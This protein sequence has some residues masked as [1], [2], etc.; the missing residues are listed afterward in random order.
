MKKLL[1]TLMLGVAAIA[2][3]CACSDS[4]SDSVD[5]PLGDVNSQ[6]LSITAVETTSTR[7]T[8]SVD[9]KDPDIPYVC[10]YADKAT[11]D[12]VPKG[13]LPQFLMDELKAQAKAQ[14]KIAAD[15]IAEI[16]LRGNIDKKTVTGLH[17]GRIYELVAFAVS[18]TTVA[19]NAE[20]LFFETLLLDPIDCSF[21][22][23]AQTISNQAL[24]DVTPSVNNEY[25]YLGV[26]KKTSYDS[27]IASGQYDDESILSNLYTNDFQRAMAQ[28]APSGAVTDE[29][30][31][32]ILD[33]VLSKGNASFGLIGLTPETE[34][35]WLAAAFR[36]A[37]IDDQ[38]VIGSASSVST[39]IFKTGP[40]EG[41]DLT[42]DLKA[43]KVGDSDVNIAITPSDNDQPYIWMAT[44]ITDQNATL[45]AQQLASLYINENND[46]LDALT[47]KGRQEKTLTGLSAG[48]RYCVVAWGNKDGSPTTLPVIY[49]FG[50]DAEGAVSRARI[51]NALQPW[52]VIDVT[53]QVFSV[54]PIR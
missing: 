18:G 29:A 45:T 9:A 52:R 34:Y 17:P 27:Y 40:K 51:D 25:Y 37:E 16:S 44:A 42:F 36:V 28:I 1:Y 13:D 8:F 24:L 5:A 49:E 6:K 48:D 33:N 43:T 41:I 47:V 3:L 2:S 35:I 32:Q 4:D 31:Q 22:V 38:V 7:F 20:F 53:L 26:L 11:I 54:F 12:A 30:L 14:G 23:D 10:V 50:L 15:Y 39:G 21:N 46:N 19:Y